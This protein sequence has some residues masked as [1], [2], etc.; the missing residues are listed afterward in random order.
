MACRQ[1]DLD[2]FFQ[3]IMHKLD[4]CINDKKSLMNQS[5]VNKER[6][7][8]LLLEELKANLSSDIQG[9]ASLQPETSRTSCSSDHTPGVLCEKVSIMLCVTCLDFR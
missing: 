3:N 6:G 2:D 8:K 9:L 1:D 4:D 5:H 7:S